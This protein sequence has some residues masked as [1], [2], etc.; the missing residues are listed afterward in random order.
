M[1]KSTNATITSRAVGTCIVCRTTSGLVRCDQVA[2]DYL[3]EDVC[4]RTV[5][6]LGSRSM[7]S[8]SGVHSTAHWTPELTDRIL[9]SLWEM[10]Y[11]LIETDYVSTSDSEVAIGPPGE[12]P[13]FS[14]RRG[15]DGHIRSTYVADVGRVQ[16]HLE[17]TLRQSIRR[18][19][20]ARLRTIY[21]GFE[22]FMPAYE[23][24]RLER[25]LGQIEKH[26]AGQ[27]FPAAT[28]PLSKQ[29]DTA[30][31]RIVDQD[32]LKLAKA[33]GGDD[34]NNPYGYSTYNEVL[35]VAPLIRDLSETNLGAL[36]WW[37]NHA[38]A[39]AE[40]RHP[41]QVIS[42]ARSTTGLDGARWRLFNNLPAE[43]IRQAGM[44]S[45]M[46]FIDV[47]V[48]GD[49]GYPV[50]W[51]PFF[52]VEL[53]ARAD[54]PMPAPSMLAA[55][56]YAWW[57]HTTPDN[58]FCEQFLKAVRLAS[59]E[60][61]RLIGMGDGTQARLVDTFYH[62]MTWVH[63]AV[64]DGVAVRATTWAGL[65]KASD[66]WHRRTAEQLRD[67]QRRKLT[68]EKEVSS[69]NSLVPR[70][71]V[72][73]FTVTPLISPFD[74]IDE[75]GLMR[76]CVADYAPSCESGE[77]RIFHIEDEVG[78]SATCEIGLIDLNRDEWSLMQ[79]AGPSNAR[80]SPAMERAGKRV[81]ELY[82]RAWRETDREHRH[83]LHRIKCPSQVDD[84]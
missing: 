82:K 10:D 42:M 46:E 73:R 43:Y 17:Y 64:T 59:L 14:I 62:V 54:A 80:V 5:C 7:S 84:A 30:V 13:G 31:K 72:G 26:V 55:F 70:Q 35:P 28:E 3:L 75:G 48:P 49:A 33:I 47:A 36:I 6:G 83:L 23:N 27:Q 60:S 2:P 11:D 61:C 51:F 41:G 71:Q 78:E 25:D 76:S 19:A 53:L 56:R 24:Q 38:E 16:E 67:K 1:K 65:H 15:A 9:D 37:W 18:T 63:Q 40:V 50:K 77:T 58:V 34:A 45:P 20:T 12:S 29:I 68:A 8:C 66:D 74:L 22:T 57:L 32:T 39:P 21:P 44:P 69:W 79:I 4:E 52:I 81:L